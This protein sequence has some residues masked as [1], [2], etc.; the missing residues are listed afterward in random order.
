M[1]LIRDESILQRKPLQGRLSPQGWQRLHELFG[2]KAT[3]AD[4][5]DRILRE[6][7]QRGERSVKEWTARL[8]GVELASLEVSRDEIEAAYRSVAPSLRRALRLAARRVRAFHKRTVPKSWFDPKTG[9]GQRVV[10]LERVGA[11]VPGGVAAYPSTVLMTVIPAKVAGVR[12]VVV[13]T[14]PGKWKDGAVSPAVLA[15]CRIA[16][17]DRVFR[18]GGAQAIAALAYGTDSVPKVDMICGP[19]NIFVTEAKRQLF[20]PV[21]IDALQGPTET[22]LIADAGADPALCAAD[23][24]AQAEHDA[25]ASPILLTDSALLA[26]KVQQEVEKQLASLERAGIARQAL[27]GQGGIV[28]VP[29]IERAIDLANQYAPEHLCLLVRQPRRWLPKVRNAGGVFLGEASPEVLGD[30]VAGPSHV[31]PTGGSAR[32]SSCLGVHDFVKVT[33]VVGLK[34]KDARALAGP[35]ETIALAEGLTAHAAAARLRRTRSR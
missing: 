21:G 24:L 31:M 32:Y 35:A 15:A 28:V 19:G 6:V 34:S 8:D 13:A 26:E 18:I 10:P 22:L 4:A 33:A 20:G 17:V 7:R 27:E 23:M 5:V 30:Y 2:P 25:L 29:S 3:V 1:N 12:E 11:Y 14:P 9:L 16:G